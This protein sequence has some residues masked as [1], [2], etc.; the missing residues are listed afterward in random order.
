MQLIDIPAARRL[1]QTVYILGNNSKKLSLLLQ[2]RE[3]F[4][5]CVGPGLRVEQL[6][7][8]KLE[9]SFCFLLIRCV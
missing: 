5:R 4:V 7:A 3:L 9:K 8:V 1:V 6:G 2:L